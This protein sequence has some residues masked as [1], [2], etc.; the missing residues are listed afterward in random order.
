MDGIGS[1]SVR[2]V[3]EAR[4]DL[5]IHVKGRGGGRHADGQAHAREANSQH[6]TKAVSHLQLSLFL[7]PLTPQ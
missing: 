7:H 4:I 1:G 2:L 3:P 6:A 5:G